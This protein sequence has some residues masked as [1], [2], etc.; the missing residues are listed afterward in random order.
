LAEDGQQAEPA[1]WGDAANTLALV[2]IATIFIFPIA[3]TIA[4]SLKTRVDAL[5]FPP[6]FLFTPTFENYRAVWSDGS[7]LGFAWNSLVVA[8]SA[9]SLGMALGVPAGYALARVDFPG[10]RVILLSI[11]STRMVP[12]IASII[13]LFIVFSSLGLKDTY[14]ALVILHLTV[15]LG[16]VIWM[17]RSYFLDIPREIEEAAMIDGCGAWGVFW[18]IVIPV[19]LPGLATSAI[20]SF[21]YSWNEFLYAMIVTSRHAKTLPLGIYSWVSYE[22]VRWGE[23]T[24]AAVLAM[25]PV[26]IFYLFV[27]RALVRGLTMG[28]VKG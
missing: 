8:T 2:V 10:R 14:T 16:F 7:I 12:P 27:Q 15:I 4:M 1:S 21:I 20:F 24:A 19:S 9:T 17:M 25:V 18:R 5:S 22:E 13:P 23:L 26:F 6:T 28:A 3:W 11:L